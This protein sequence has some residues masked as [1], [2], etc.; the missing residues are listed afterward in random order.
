MLLLVKIVDLFC[1]S[2]RLLVD[3]TQ[4]LFSMSGALTELKSE[5]SQLIVSIL[6]VH[7]MPLITIS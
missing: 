3:G 2:G 4:F 7:M 5:V 6:N 1:T